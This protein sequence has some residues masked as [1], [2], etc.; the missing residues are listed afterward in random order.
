MCVAKGC[1]GERMTLLRGSK[2]DSTCVDGHPTCM[3]ILNAAV[4]AQSYI[5][6]SVTGL[7]IHSI[8]VA[9]YLQLYTIVL[10]E[11]ISQLSFQFIIKQNIISK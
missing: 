7:Y 3:C 9:F 4:V 6:G 8:S 5:H 2:I 11:T 10:W 1:V